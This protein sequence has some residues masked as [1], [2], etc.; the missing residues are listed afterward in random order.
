MNLDD[1]TRLHAESDLT[2]RAQHIRFRG[3]RCSMRGAI[4]FN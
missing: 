1:T 3:M 4:G 2:F